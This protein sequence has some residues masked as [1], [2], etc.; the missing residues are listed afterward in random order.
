MRSIEASSFPAVVRQDQPAL[1]CWAI[2]LPTLTLYPRL[3]YRRPCSRSLLY[4]IRSRIPPAPPAQR[5]AHHFQPQYVVLSPD[6]EN[7]TMIRLRVISTEKTCPIIIVGPLISCSQIFQELQALSENHILGTYLSR[8]PVRD[9]RAL[10]AFDVIVIAK[11]KEFLVMNSIY[12][13][14][15]RQ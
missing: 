15:Y 10:P 1:S 12:T 13:Y 7:S 4:Y 9:K 5:K 3:Y 6:V 14:V 2:F 11:T 8:G